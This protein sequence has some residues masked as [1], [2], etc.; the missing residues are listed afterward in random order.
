[1]K[2]HLTHS[3]LPLFVRGCGE[4]YVYM[5]LIGSNYIFQMWP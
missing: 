3:G 5:L 1:M 4:V 2:S